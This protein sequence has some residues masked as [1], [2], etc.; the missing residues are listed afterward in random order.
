MIK[1]LSNRQPQPACCVTH[2]PFL[3]Q[4]KKQ[5]RDGAPVNNVVNEEFFGKILALDL[6]KTVGKCRNESTTRSRKRNAT[7]ESVEDKNDDA[8]S[9]LSSIESKKTDSNANETM[10]VTKQ[11]SNVTTPNSQNN[12]NE[13]ISPQNQYD[14]KLSSID[15]SA[16]NSA[17]EHRTSPSPPKLE[18]IQTAVVVSHSVEPQFPNLTDNSSIKDE[19]LT[20]LAK[21]VP[22]KRKFNPS[23]MEGMMAV[24][25]SKPFEPSSVITRTISQT[26]NM[27][28]SPPQLPFLSPNGVD[29]D[30]K[31]WKGHRVLAK[32]NV[33]YLPGVIKEL[34]NGCDIVILFD[35]QSTKCILD[36]LGNGRYDVISDH[37]PSPGQVKIGTSVCVR[38]NQDENVFAVGEVISINPKPSFKVK[39]E[40][41]SEYGPIGSTIW[42]SRAN[43]RLLLPPWWEELDMDPQQSMPFTPAPPQLSVSS[44]SSSQ[45]IESSDNLAWRTLGTPIEHPTTPTS[46]FTQVITNHQNY[47]D[48]LVESELPGTLVQPLRMPAA[49]SEMYSASPSP[50]RMQVMP[51]PNTFASTS[52][53]QLVHEAV[54]SKKE[55]RNPHFDDESSDDELKKE[56]IK[57]DQDYFTYP[58]QR[59]SALSQGSLTPR[60]Q[61]RK[62]ET[63]LSRA[64]TDS[65]ECL[66]TSRSPAMMNTKYKKGDIVSTPNGIRKKFNGKQWRRLCSKEGCTKESQRRGFCSRHLSLRGKNIRPPSLSFPGRRKGTFKDSATGRELEWEESSHDSESNPVFSERDR[67]QGRFD[68]DETEAANMLVSLGNSRSAT[69][70]FSPNNTPNPISPRTFQTPNSHFTP[71]GH[72]QR[73]PTV[74]QQPA[75][76]TIS[77]Q[78]TR[79]LTGPS[80]IISNNYPSSVTNPVYHPGAI[81]TE[82]IQHPVTIQELNVQPETRASVLQ[83]STN[84]SDSSV[85][86]AGNQCPVLFRD[87]QSNVMENH[88]QEVI[89][90]A[91][92]DGIVTFSQENVAEVMSNLEAAAPHRIPDSQTVLLF[93]K[94]VR[95]EPPQFVNEEPTV[96]TT[97]PSNNYQP[98]YMVS[99]SVQEDSLQ[100]YAKYTS[101][102]IRLQNMIDKDPKI[103]CPQPLTPIQLLPVMPIPSSPE[104]KDVS[105]DNG[106]NTSAWSDARPIPVFPWHSLVPFL[107][108][109]SSVNSN[110]ESKSSVD[111]AAKEPAPPEPEEGDDDV[112]VTNDNLPLDILDPTDKRRT[113]SLSAL[114][115]EELKSPKKPAS[116]EKDHIRRPMN[117][118][119]IFSKRHRALVHQRHPNQDNR[120]VS[121]ILG[122]WWYAL[123]PERKQK[124]HD[125]AYEVKEAHFKAYP[126]WKWCS[127]DRKKS[128]TSSAP[129]DNQKP[130]GIDEPSTPSMPLAEKVSI[131]DDLL[132][133][134]NDAA[135]SKKSNDGI[136]KISKNSV[137]EKRPRSRSLSQLPDPW[138][139]S[140]LTKE[141]AKENLSINDKENKISLPPCGD[142]EVSSFKEKLKKRTSFGKNLNG[143]S[144]RIDS[145]TSDDERMVIC[146]EETN[147]VSEK[148]SLC[149]DEPPIDLKCK[150]KVTESDTESQSDDESLIENKAFPQQRFSPV[151]KHSSSV[152]VTHRPKPIKAHPSTSQIPFSISSSN[153]NNSN[154]PLSSPGNGH[155]HR[156]LPTAS[157]FQPTGAVFK[158]VHSPKVHAPDAFT[159]FS[160]E[161]QKPSIIVT[162][163]QGIN[164]RISETLDMP[165]LIPKSP[166]VKENA[167]NDP[168]LQPLHNQKSP[169]LDQI[170]I[171]RTG[172]TSK[173]RV[174]KTVQ[175]LSRGSALPPLLTIPSINLNT[176]TNAVQTTLTKSIS[177]HTPNI[178][179]NLQSLQIPNSTIPVQTDKSKVQLSPI[180]A[181]LIQ[182]SQGFLV[183]NGSLAATHYSMAILSPPVSKNSASSPRVSPALNSPEYLTATLKNLVIPASKQNGVPSTPQTPSTPVSQM[184]STTVLANL[185]L[186]T[187]AQMPSQSLLSSPT[188]PGQLHLSPQFISRSGTQVQYLFPSLT[189]QS[190]NMKSMVQMAVPAQGS[191]QLGT[192]T[193][194]ASGVPPS[195]TGSNTKY[196]ANGHGN[197]LT[198]NKVSNACVQGVIV[199]KQTSAHPVGTSQVLTL[200]PAISPVVENSRLHLTTVAQTYTITTPPTSAATQR[201]ILPSTRRQ[202]TS[203]G[204]PA[205][206]THPVSLISSDLSPSVP[207]TLIQLQPYTAVT[208]QKEPTSYV[209]V[210]Q[211]KPSSVTLVASASPAVS[212]R[213]SISTSRS[214]HNRSQSPQFYAGIMDIKSGALSTTPVSLTPNSKGDLTFSAHTFHPKPQKVKATVANVPLATSVVESESASKTDS[215]NDND[216]SQSDNSKPQRSCKGKRYKELVAEGGIRAKKKPPKLGIIS[217]ISQ[218]AESQGGNESNDIAS[219]LNGTQLSSLPVTL[220]SDSA[221]PAT[222][223]DVG[224]EPSSASSPQVCFVLAPTPAQLGRAPG[225]LNQRRSSESQDAATKA[226]VEED[227]EQNSAD[228][229]QIISDGSQQE[230]LSPK[231]TNMKRAADDGMDKVLEQVDFE[232]RFAS[233][234]QFNPEESPSATAASLPNSPRAFV[235]SYRKKRRLSTAQDQDDAEPVKSP[236]KP[237]GQSSSSEA[238]TPKTPKSAAVFEGNKFFGP[239][240]T[241]EDFVESECS[242]THSPRTPK[243]PNDSDKGMSS[244]RR[245]LDQRR[246]LVMQLLKDVGLFPT[247]QAT[248]QFQHNHQEAFPT[249][250][251]L[252]LKIREVRQKLMAQSAGT[253]QPPTTPTATSSST[254]SNNNTPTTNTRPETTEGSSHPNTWSQQFLVP[255][256]VGTN[257]KLRPISSSDGVKNSCYVQ[258]KHQECRTET[259]A[260]SSEQS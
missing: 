132:L 142:T 62:S 173:P 30:L 54:I 59:P 113:Q 96:I 150:E 95:N 14:N 66:G 257:S 90:K 6:S 89:M 156:P 83:F 118:F 53:E 241:I 141:D 179:R 8:R 131:S 153:S 5:L 4:E 227:E 175:K 44:Q 166:S 51:V 248:A 212:P 220:A 258:D 255:G 138:H 50:S 24:E 232:A 253:P 237:K 137:F 128:S 110:S 226:V 260:S 108:T 39:L 195:L 93:K 144:T 22:K 123:E 1:N 121:K 115:K 116:R 88:K 259:V 196:I 225:Q 120:T 124:Y 177:P 75:Q 47:P 182:T 42:V 19:N 223:D 186:K 76:W 203:P 91:S 235:N 125:L 190:P 187:S 106:K 129:K 56:D 57:F 244:Q 213:T 16:N 147:S 29:I 234:P 206:A 133:N 228:G 68:R 250:N 217:E 126:N 233:L 149:I 251:T 27:Q 185:V 202:V 28:T 239:N 188:S 117:A 243:T 60:S 65:S 245:I 20:L 143:S 140:L 219:N 208:P 109:N 205:V 216:G 25:V 148:P 41:T 97:L 151:M 252:Q 165:S 92:K 181:S 159:A 236:C 134:Y 145:D 155:F 9:P 99:N 105:L 180:S 176:S 193:T 12:V 222:V 3:G 82:V 46:A 154:H 178:S 87:S 183:S 218:T 72:P 38:V 84:Q 81:R 15:S 102:D 230:P 174:Q 77:P 139:A 201:L 13:R 23:E 249:K 197:S 48:V 198:S 136:M 103:D 224:S 192:P 26:S 172:E 189:L 200:A 67:V 164:D 31:D 111:P 119:M 18:C 238:G 256:P 199:N 78:D 170:P 191:I 17:Q 127:R 240:F 55:L 184:A 40:H 246:S 215:K 231:K 73:S 63:V 163:E 162:S 45:L 207:G 158:D 104:K 114:P 86:Q 7:A 229:K 214:P 157:N 70:A 152:E 2:S 204:S 168:Q 130:I 35:N 61:S 122:E 112:F 101:G 167:N 34:K 58:Y 74:N 160:V 161:H 21:Q 209:T 169:A 33:I 221:V 79:T 10:T 64:S 194:H 71:I 107:T 52:S 98:N 69:P 80:E 210:N 32:Y 100:E 247:A 11:V 37:S 146:E 49:G 171:T 211:V 135:T 254:N 85:I 36:V 242:S 94:L 43:L